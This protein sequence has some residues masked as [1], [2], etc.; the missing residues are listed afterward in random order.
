MK[1]GDLAKR[2]GLT[3]AT[4]RFYESKGLITA[5]SRRANGYR[6]YP[7]EAVAVLTIITNA[8]QTGF[9]LDQIKHVLPGNLS[10][11]KHDELLAMLKTKI[12]DIDAM[13]R[14]LAQSKAQ[15][16]D[17]IGLIEAK[18]DGMDCDDNAVRIMNNM[19]LIPSITTPTKE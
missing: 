16:L 18:P 17:L 14:K 2:T 13:Q 3:P 11:W 7:A 1:I 5:V 9:T 15:L 8:Q 19:G 10:H 4:I 6:E 12:D